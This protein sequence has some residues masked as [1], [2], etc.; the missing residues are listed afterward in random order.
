MS[1]L[2]NDLQILGCWRKSR[3]ELIILCLYVTLEYKQNSGFQAVRKQHLFCLSCAGAPA[4]KERLLFPECCD[5]YIS[6]C[7]AAEQPCKMQNAQPSS[8]QF[9]G[10]ITNVLISFIV[11]WQVL[12]ACSVLLCFRQCGR[13]LNLWLDVKGQRG[14]GSTGVSSVWN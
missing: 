6:A 3:G 8:T 13:N 11:I 7:L 14:L 9:L 5:C 4:G 12:Y 2:Q 1:S 10:A